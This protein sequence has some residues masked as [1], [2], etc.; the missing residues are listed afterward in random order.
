MGFKWGGIVAQGLLGGAVAGFGALSTMASDRNKADLE[1]E[2][3][4]RLASLTE[5]RDTKQFAQQTA[6]QESSQKFQGG[7]NQKTREQADAHFQATNDLAKQTL[8]ETVRGNQVREGQADRQIAVSEKHLRIAGAQLQETINQNKKEGQAVATADGTLVWMPKGGGKGTPMLDDKDQPLRGMDPVRA[9]AF[10]ASHDAV[11]NA[12][13]NLADARKNAMGDD[14]NPEVIAAAEVYRG[15][16]AIA[17]KLNPEYGKAAT[18]IKTQGQDP[19]A[20]ARAM[21]ARGA[22]E[23]ELKRLPP[24]V[25]EAARKP[26][27][28]PMS[29]PAATPSVAAPPRRFSGPAST[30]TGGIVGDFDPL[31]PNRILNNG[32]PVN[33]NAHIGSSH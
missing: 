20:L 18:D 4:L 29:A 10:K 11:Q 21:I 19:V 13:K 2:R 32:L 7:E 14:K 6:L 30:S 12:A 31:A 15:A 27:G 16:Q 9:E 3:D 25:L 33:P 22:P 5:Q 28:A 17:A 26:A 1:K 8:E 23:S 24:D